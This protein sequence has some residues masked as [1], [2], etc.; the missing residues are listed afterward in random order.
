MKFLILSCGTGGGHNDAGRGAAEALRAAG[1]EAVFLN[2]YLGLAGKRVDQL[3]CSLYMNTVT[4]RPGL[5]RAVYGLGRGVSSALRPLGLKSPVYRLNAGRLARALG[6]L[7]ERERFDAVIM[8]H[9]YPAETL[10]ALKRRGFP[11]PPTIAVATDHTAIPFW[12]ET[13]CDWYIVPDTDTLLD[14]ERRGVPR[15][16]LVPL[17]IP[18]PLAFAPPEDRA[19]VRAALGFRPGEK[20]I[21]LMSGSM[22]AGDIEGFIRALRARMD[23]D[24]HLIAVCGKNEPLWERLRLIYGSDPQVTVI[25]YLQ[26][27]ARYMQACDLLFTKPG[28]LTTTES[29]L[30]RIPTV[31]LPAISQC[32]DANRKAFLKAHAACQGADDAERIG[33]GLKLLLPENAAR[34][35][36]AQQKMLPENPAVK[37]AAFAERMVIMRDDPGSPG[38]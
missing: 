18:A 13:A 37:L 34:M 1:H 20:Y 16:K 21:L 22:G 24:A 15:E 6:A 25:G 4:R 23:G 38:A 30:C 32:E 10:T 35:R 11:L 36:R 19:A 26:D 33:R 29:A 8:S 17:G 14:F 12:E 5:F 31:L 27:T 7:I 2:E 3:I 9:L 28:G